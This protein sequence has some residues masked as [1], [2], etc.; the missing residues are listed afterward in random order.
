[1]AEPKLPEPPFEAE[2]VNETKL[3]CLHCTAAVPLKPGDVV[4]VVALFGSDLGYVVFV[5][6]SDTRHIG[7]LER[8]LNGKEIWRPKKADSAN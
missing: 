4:Q 2:I 8:V 3:P 6:G 5:D 7:Q 1:M